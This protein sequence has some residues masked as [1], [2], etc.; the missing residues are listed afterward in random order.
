[1]AWLIFWGSE[2][3]FSQRFMDDVLRDCKNFSEAYDVSIFSTLWSD[4]CQYI[5]QVLTRL[6]TAGLMANAIKC[7]WGQTACTYTGHM[8]SNRMVEPAAGKVQALKD[9]TRPITKKC[10]NFW[11]LRATIEGYAPQTFHLTEETKKV[12]P[13]NYCMV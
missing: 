2:C 13:D 10:D 3:L 12:A 7:A 4:H 9:F 5:E 8:V 11:V 6:Q 1:M